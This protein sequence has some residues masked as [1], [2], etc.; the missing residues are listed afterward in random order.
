MSGLVA[1]REWERI[2]GRLCAVNAE[3]DEGLELMNREVMTRAEIKS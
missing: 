3:L 1:E 2:L